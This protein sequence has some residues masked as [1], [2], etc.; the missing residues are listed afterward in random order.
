MKKIL[1]LL[2][3]TLMIFSIASC[4]G[5]QE[6]VQGPSPTETMDSFLQAIKARDFDTAAQY[7][8]G[9]IGDLSA[10]EETED[11]VMSGIINSLVDKMLDFD[12][13][14]S[15]EKIKND[16]A[17]VD[18]N[19]TTYDLAKIMNELIVGILT[20]APAL[21]L[22]GMDQEEMEA[23]IAEILSIQFKEAMDGAAK[24]TS[25]TI[26]V[27]LVKKDGNWLVKDLSS[28][29]D[30][31]NALSGGILEYANGIEDTIS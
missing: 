21:G 13:T 14:L 22:T 31:M 6:D 7:Y 10:I 5:A 23:E 1:S 4:G 24:D 30:F 19:F 16:T 15:D 2:L 29:D 12:Y 28:A 26:T 11:P 17:T 18:V 3:I 25:M 27:N 20:D 9:D 8:E